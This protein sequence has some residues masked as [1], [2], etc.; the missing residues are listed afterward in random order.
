M[1]TIS[2]G[3]N[4]TNLHHSKSSDTRLTN[5]TDMTGDADRD[6]G[7]DTDGDAG[8]DAD[9]DAGGGRGGGGKVNGPRKAS[10]IVLL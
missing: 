8:G 3:S 1:L 5:H 4:Q 6:V 9:A 2:K 7:G 10:R